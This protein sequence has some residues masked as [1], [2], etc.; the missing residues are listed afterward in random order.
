[1]YQTH[2][3]LQQKTGCLQWPFPLSFVDSPGCRRAAQ[4][5]SGTDGTNGGA[6]WHEILLYRDLTILLLKKGSLV[7][8][9]QVRNPGQL[10]FTDFYHH[11]F[12]GSTT[13]TIASCCCEEI[14]KK[15]GWQIIATKMPIGRPKRWLHS[16]EFRDIFAFN[17]RLGLQ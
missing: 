5:S 6:A 16:K 13:S 7:V 4:R 11:F 12:L 3:L 9:V 14:L 2:V 1:M 10:V 17:S 15:F 8:V